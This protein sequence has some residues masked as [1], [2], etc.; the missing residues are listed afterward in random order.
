M[1]NRK[2]AKKTTPEEKAKILAYHAAGWKQPR[3]AARMNRGK[4]CIGK[5][6]ARYSKAAELTRKRGSGFRGPLPKRMKLT[7][8]QKKAAE[9]AI[10]EAKIEAFKDAGV[11]DGKMTS[12]LMAYAVAK[13]GKPQA[14]EAAAKDAAGAAEDD[15][16]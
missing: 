14:A 16:A 6:I 11:D 12:L 3:I 8:V 2:K 7:S 9:L 15:S 13:H 4:S 10:L 5:I 1:L